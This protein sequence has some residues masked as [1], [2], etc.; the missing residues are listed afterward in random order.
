[1]EAIDGRMDGWMESHVNPQLCG[2]NAFGLRL[3]STGVPPL[4][5]IANI[6]HVLRI[7]WQK[8]VRLL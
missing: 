2:N 5:R 1:V 4:R 6:L 8:A 7:K 3:H